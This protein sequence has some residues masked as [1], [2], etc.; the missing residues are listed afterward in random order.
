MKSI[1]IGMS[2]PKTGQLGVER[3]LDAQVRSGW[4]HF[5]YPDCLARQERFGLV[6]GGRS[7]QLESVRRVLGGQETWW[8]SDHQSNGLGELMGLVE[9]KLEGHPRGSV[10]DDIGVCV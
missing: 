7:R 4:W 3:L 10:A 1:G 8:R 2:T 5:R 6:G 9:E